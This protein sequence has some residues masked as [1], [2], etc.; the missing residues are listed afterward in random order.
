VRIPR[1]E[2]P[3]P[4]PGGL[5]PREDELFL[6]D[7]ADQRDGAVE[8]YPPR[9]GR[10]GLVEQ[11][12]AL[13]ELHL[14]A[15]TGELRDLGVGEPVEQGDGAEVVDEAHGDGETDRTEG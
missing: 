4:L 2:P 9:I 5:D 10:P 6:A 7:P 11:F 8:Q 15:H 12:V 14:L 1:A 3:G 13:V